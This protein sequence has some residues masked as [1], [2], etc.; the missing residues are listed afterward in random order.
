MCRWLA[1]YLYV[2]SG[3]SHNRAGL[4][5]LVQPSMLILSVG[6]SRRVQLIGNLVTTQAWLQTGTTLQS[7]ISVEATPL[8]W[9]FSVGHWKKDNCLAE[10]SS[11]HCLNSGH[12]S[13]TRNKRLTLRNTYCVNDFLL[14]PNRRWQVQRFE[15]PTR[16]DMV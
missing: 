11:S 4:V 7:R 9:P 8:S 12:V 15:R 1:T 6:Q 16:A 10:K 3:G 13:F 5:W 14:A 2:A